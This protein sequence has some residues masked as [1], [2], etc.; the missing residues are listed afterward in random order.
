MNK[1]LSEDNEDGHSNQMMLKYGISYPVTWL[2]LSEKM[3][4]L[5]ET[6]CTIEIRNVIMFLCLKK[7]SP[8]EI[9]QQLIEV[10]STSV[11]LKNIH[12]IW[13]RQNRC[14]RWRK[15]WATQHVIADDT[16]FHVKTLIQVLTSVSHQVIFV[17]SD[18]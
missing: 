18:L 14:T 15:S 6:W 5:V 12:G 2:N 4:A 13:Q 3:A 17:S 1:N 9:H 8:A 10:Y 7:N 16:V 11:M